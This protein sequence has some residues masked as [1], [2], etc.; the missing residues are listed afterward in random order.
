MA[1]TSK[2]REQKKTTKQKSDNTDPAQEERSTKAD[3]TC[4]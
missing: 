1:K 2:A 4:Q 3:N